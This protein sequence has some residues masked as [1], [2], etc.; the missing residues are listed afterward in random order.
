MKIK[1]FFAAI[2]LAFRTLGK[3]ALAALT[4][5]YGIPFALAPAL[6]VLFVT[7]GWDWLWYRAVYGKPLLAALGMAANI[8]GWAVPI[9]LPFLFI[10]IGACANREPLR[11]RG[12]GMTQAAMLA[13]AV[14]ILLKSFTGR[15][16]AGVF[17]LDAELNDYS[18]QFDWG[19]WHDP[20]DGWPSGH[21]LNSVA[22][23]VALSE[24]YPGS[25]TLKA[26]TYLYLLLIAVG[27]TLCD[28]WASDVIAGILMGWSIGKA[29]GKGFKEMI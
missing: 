19:F 22:V 3:N 15:R 2:A 20:V 23:V 5:L 11:I 6:T 27:M 4:W 29:V 25:K 10:L 24:M 13:S 28:H 17:D 14:N 16:Q 8:A 18:G 26:A 12:A 21:V 1:L 7:A 9:L